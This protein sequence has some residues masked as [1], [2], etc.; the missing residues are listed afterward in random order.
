MGADLPVTEPTGSMVV[1]IGGGTTEVAVISLGGIVTSSSLRLAGNRLDEAIATVSYTHLRNK[2]FANMCQAYVAAGK[3]AKAVKAFES[4]LADQT[5]VFNDAAN[6]DYQRAIQA[7]A[8][9]VTE[10]EHAPEREEKDLSGLDV[11]GSA[12]PFDVA[13]DRE[14]LA[15]AGTMELSS[16]DIND[17]VD[18]YGNP[19]DTNFFNENDVR[20]QDW[21]RSA[22]KKKRK[23]GIVVAVIVIIIVAALVG[24][25]AYVVTQGFGLSLIHIFQ[26]NMASGCQACRSSSAMRSLRSMQLIG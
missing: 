18:A 20:L 26:L 5:Y 10:E 7:V 13:D 3:M 2:L 16:H 1:D 17:Q 6:V 25:A 24:G 9:G 22:T 8:S 4:A 14:H 19:Y 15:E 11:S 23:K 21:A 12:V